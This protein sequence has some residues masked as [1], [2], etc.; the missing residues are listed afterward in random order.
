MLPRIWVGIS[1]WYHILGSQM[2]TSKTQGR[3]KLSLGTR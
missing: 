3:C 2:K 1:W